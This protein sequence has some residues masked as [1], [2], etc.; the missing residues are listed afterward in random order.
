MAEA[1]SGKLN[2]EKDIKK[3]F[4]DPNLTV[5]HTRRSDSMRE[6]STSV[7]VN[8]CLYTVLVTDE[9]I[10]KLR[11]KKYDAVMMQCRFVWLF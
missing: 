4:V 8:A 6:T 9:P 3:A 1:G 5:L 2:N 11:L 7:P 10:E